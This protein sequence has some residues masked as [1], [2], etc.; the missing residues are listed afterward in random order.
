MTTQIFFFDYLQQIQKSEYPMT[1]TLCLSRLPEK[2][3]IL[4]IWEPFLMLLLLVV[5]LKFCLD[6]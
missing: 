2:R 6:E 3:G 4:L 1:H 5:V